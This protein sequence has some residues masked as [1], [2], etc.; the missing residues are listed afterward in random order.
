[1]EEDIL[2][3]IAIATYNRV[4]ALERQ[5]NNIHSQLVNSKSAQYIEVLVSDNNSTDTTQNVVKDFIEMDKQYKLTCCKNKENIGSGLNYVHSII[6]S[7][8]LFVWLMSDDDKILDGSVQYLYDI[9]QLNQNIGFGF[10]NFFFEGENSGK[11]GIVAKNGFFV[12]SN[13]DLLT[14]S[15]IAASM[16]SSCIFRKSL[17]SKNI[18]IDEANELPGYHHLFS[19]KRLTQMA[20]TLVITKPLFIV[21]EPDVYER[22]RF[23]KTSEDIGVD[24]YMKAHITFIK[25]ISEL[26]KSSLLFRTRFKLYRYIN[27]ENLNQIIYHKITSEKYDISTIKYVLPIMI[28]RFYFSSFFWLVHIPILMLPAFFAKFIEP[29]RWEY[30]KLRGK[31]GILATIL[32]KKTNKE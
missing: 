20:D 25:F 6:K 14:P 22:R 16:I 13:I 2:L 26:I 1:M 17:L 3:T 5:L 30:I 4:D 11:T 32:L 8:G 19:A 10:I 18:L 12:S 28:K 23:V 31:A 29:Y 27:N 9:L 21:V 7:S 24:Y 15:L